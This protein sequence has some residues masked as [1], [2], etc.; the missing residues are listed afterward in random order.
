MKRLLTFFVAF[1][2]AAVSFYSST[3]AVIDE[4]IL[5][6]PV[7]SVYVGR[8]E[9][10]NLINNL[11]FLD[12]PASHPNKESVIRLGALNIV[13]PYDRY[14]RPTE[15]MSNEEAI[16]LILRAVGQELTAQDMAVALQ[17]T[18]PVGSPLRT[19]WSLGYL[20]LA[21]S[22]NIIT[23]EQ[24]ADALTVDQTILNPETA[25][26]REAPVSRE[27]FADWL[28][29]IVQN[30]NG[31]AFDLTRIEQGIFRYS[32]WQD[33]DL[34]KVRSVELLAENSAIRVREDGRFDPKGTVTNLDGV[35]F[36]ADLDNIYLRALGMEKHVATVGAI[37]DAQMNTSAAATLN[38]QFFLRAD[39]G[40]VD[41]MALVLNQDGTPQA[42]ATDIPVFKKGEVTGLAA[43]QEGDKI[44]FIINPITKAILYI[45]VLDDMLNLSNVLGY[46]ESVNVQMGSI[47][48]KDATGKSFVY[49]MTGGMYGT[50]N[51]VDYIYIDGR[52][53]KVSTLPIGSMVELSL[54]NMVVT[55]ILY[56]GQPS[57]VAETKG[58]VIEN[59]PELGY[60]T[61]IDN[62]GNYLTKY[63][64]TSE[65]LV[66]KHNY[67]ETTDE[68]GY[69]SQ[70]FPN[71]T[72]NPFDSK[73][74]EIEP[75]DIV[76]LRTDPQNSERIVTI[77]ASTNYIAKYG[78][79]K[80]FD[81]D[82]DVTSMVLEYENKQ[83]GYFEMATNI[84]I[85]KSGKALKPSDVQVGDYARILINQAVLE[86][87][88]ML[89]SI[90]EM[91]LEP[92]GH[93][94]TSI[95]KGQLNS[96]NSVQNQLL[97][98]NTLTLTD[99]NWDNYQNI[100]KLSIASRDIEYY[101][102][103]ERISLDYAVKNF[104]RADMDVY[105][106]LEN[107]FTGDKIRKV[108]FR[109]GRDE[110]LNADIVLDA[111]GYGGF[112]IMS[113]AG[114]IGTDNGTI[115]RRY[116]RLVDGFNI[117]SAD[118]AHVSLNGD[119][120]A[121]IVDIM[122]AP[123]TK[124]VM[125]ARGRILSI[126][127]GKSFKVQTMSLLSGVQYA[128]TPIAREFSIDY[129]TKIV[130]DGN[131]V[132]YDEFLG[133]TE[134]TNINKTFNIAIDGTRA[135][136]I[137]DAPYSTKAVRGTIYS[138]EADGEEA[139]IGLKDASYY[140]NTTGKWITVNVKDSTLS[141]TVPANALIAKDNDIVTK[142][143]FTIGQQ[144]RV[145]TDKLPDKVV[146]GTEVAGYIVYVEK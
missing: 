74:E 39:D 80:S 23:P 3:Y 47:N 84:L 33:I 62:R 135:S 13:K 118:Y 146:S 136:H 21:Q 139:K 54:S 50:E 111:D 124:G 141:V 144:L 132:P 2:V 99:Y 134:G 123:D 88:I 15:N 86:P 52:K 11:N 42:G 1:S 67:Y 87:G 19:M 8:Q 61:V 95:L 58:I 131:L 30:Y 130:I 93:M 82:G 142:R 38:R 108:T 48:V 64:T 68:V 79:I 98:Q 41:R 75:G 121:A 138:I 55:R 45:N 40:R 59:M 103:N 57:I 94:I 107:N 28:V 140:D 83:T 92:S 89:E 113:N 16:A 31:T 18:F 114:T 6:E 26:L 25:F 43:L 117:Q 14:F 24:Y 49:N 91:A 34:N 126:D 27:Q 77:S 17:N 90:K 37:V 70:I 145:M 143:E 100:T 96:I 51:K 12:L 72:F 106:A 104:K 133:Y 102:N 76:F 78:K 63:Y 122:D 110:L 53:Q 20:A 29:R 7:R 85:S 9:G 109:D 36:I 71:F 56:L 66:K 73:I 22:L 10:T 46:L 137:T 44:Q 101:Y 4:M 125:V 65:I 119:S 32:D 129:N 128:Y 112:K 120:M 60:L 81:I 127:E 97:L 116:G 69:L 115:V 105:V 35:L 5:R